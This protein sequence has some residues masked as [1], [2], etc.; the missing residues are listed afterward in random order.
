MGELK[1]AAQQLGITSTTLREQGW[2]TASP[3]RIETV[4]NDPPDWLITARGRRRV[5]KEKQQRLRDRK[6][7]AARLGIRAQA[8]VEHDIC[9]GNV[10]TLLAAPP[11]WL[12]L[13]QE[14]H[15][16]QVEREEKDH[17]LR[18]LTEQMVTSVHE[19]W[20]QELKCAFTDEEADAL[21]AQWAPEVK[22]AKQD[23]KRM[24]EEMSP[25]QIKAHIDR[26][27][28]TSARAAVQRAKQLVTRALVEQAFGGDDAQK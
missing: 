10:K 24:I 3:A 13:E 16:A 1:R 12:L 17:L 20:F 6:T 9:P 7:I 4:K 19:S 14:R 2:S 28:D 5:K 22:R 23:A 8:V 26:E 15:R 21:D 18:E 27:K 11:E 25:D